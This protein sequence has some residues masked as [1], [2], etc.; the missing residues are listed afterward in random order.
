MTSKGGALPG[1][2]RTMQERYARAPKLANGCCVTLALL[3]FATRDHLSQGSA[4]TG[5]T[6]SRSLVEVRE[7]RPQVTM[8]RTVTSFETAEATGRVRK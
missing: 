1:L 7:G 2:V 5:L 4:L 3:L 6:W 8:V